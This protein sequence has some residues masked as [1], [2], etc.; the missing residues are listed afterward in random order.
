MCALKVIT[1]M[2]RSGD[3]IPEQE[4]RYS[5]K[6]NSAGIRRD[7]IP[8]KVLDPFGSNLVVQLLCSLKASTE[9]PYL[10]RGI[11]MSRIGDIVAKSTLNTYESLQEYAL[12]VAE[13][14]TKYEYQGISQVKVQSNFPYLES[15]KGWKQEKDKTSLE[16]LGLRASIQTTQESGYIQSAG[17]TVSNLTA[18]PCV[19]STYC[20]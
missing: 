8:V 7:Y 19:Q 12:T 2:E 17:I 9:V 1:E 3:D 5:F 11:H 4:P 10:K 6:I 18:C 16:H 15:V 20:L 14:L 13:L